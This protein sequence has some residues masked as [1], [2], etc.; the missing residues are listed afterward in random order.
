MKLDKRVSIQEDIHTVNELITQSASRCPSDS[1]SSGEEGGGKDKDKHDRHRRKSKKKD[2]RLNFRRHLSA[3]FLTKSKSDT[4]FT[5]GNKSSD[6]T[7]H[8]KQ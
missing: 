6:E 3:P 8:N 1:E 4:H 5:I 2:D 7:I